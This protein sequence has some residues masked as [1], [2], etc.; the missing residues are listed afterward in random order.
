MKTL[1]LFSRVAAFGLLLAPLGAADAAFDRF[2]DSLAAEWM[3]ANPAAATAQQ[4][5]S[6]PEQDA[7]DRQLAP[8]T[9]EERA[10]RRVLAQRGLDELQRLDASRFSED[11]RI[12]AA[13]LEWQLRD[14]IAGE[15]L[16]EFDYVFNQFRGL[17]VTLVNFLSQTHPIRHRRDIENYL[18]RLALVAA[19]I[20]EGIVL[21][22]ERDAAGIRPPRF[23]LSATIDQL[24]RFLV[25]EPRQNV[26]V[27]SLEERAAK[28]GD[29]PRDERAQLVG[30]A[31]RIVAS[32]IVPAF[33]RVQ[34]LLQEQLPRAA[35]A[36]GLGQFP[37]GDRAYAL[38]LR[39]NTTTTL[40]AEEIHALGLR[41]VARIEA[42][43]DKILRALG[44]AEGSV[45]DRYKR[46]EADLQPKEA[47]PRATLLARYTELVRDAE[48]R[49]TLLFDLR[50]QAPCEVRREPAFTEKNIRHTTSIHVCSGC[51]CRA[52]RIAS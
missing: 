28:L 46:L 3:R 25:N 23:I 51:R 22:R 31:E 43:M 48:K 50:P 5:F 11:Q 40:S 44:Y 8:V 7:L 15:E 38:A 34:A 36:A 27:T 14:L 35:D 32:Q 39:R 30:E 26:L 6:G 52:R 21:A 4:F 49:A 9:K 1:R 13:M 33:R 17:Q 41:E 45:K 19:R 20:D 16:D 2:A 10:K 18:A 29:L 47:D 37:G 24:G 12:S 42:Q